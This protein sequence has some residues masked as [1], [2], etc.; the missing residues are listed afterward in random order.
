MDLDL[1]I[2][3]DAT[4]KSFN[5]LTIWSRARANFYQTKYSEALKDFNKLLEIKP[6][7]TL[8]LG[9]RGETY[10][11]LEKY[12][13][14]LIDFNNL[15]EKEP[16]NYLAL[17]LR[18][19]TYLLLENYNEAL[20][21]F[22]NLLEKDPNNYRALELR[23]KTYLMLKKYNEALIDFNKLLELEPNSALA[24]RLRGDTYL[25]S[26]KYNEALM[27][28]NKS[29]ELEPNNTFALELR[30]ETYLKLKNYH[31]ALTD[32]NNLLEKEPNNSRASE[33]RG[34]TYLLSEKY[35]EALTDFNNLL[36]N[37][38]NN[39]RAL[40]LR[41]ETYLKLKKYNEALMD[42][43]LLEIQLNNL[44]F[45]EEIID[46]YN[47]ILKIEPNNTLAL[48]FRGNNYKILKKYKEALHDFNNILKINPDDI[49]VLNLIIETEKNKN[50]SI[51]IKTQKQQTRIVNDIIT[52]S[53]EFINWIP[54]SQFKDIKYIAEGG[55]GVVNSAILI[56][57]KENEIKV[58]LKNLHNSKDMTDDFLKEVI[59]HGITSS[60]DFI[61]QCY[62]ITKDPNTN[63]NIMVMEFAEDGNLHK[64]LMLNFD[65][66][67]W[68]TKL[69]RLYCIATGL[70]QIH[71]NKLIHRD[72]HSGNILMG[73]NGILGS[74]RIADLG[75]CR[76]IDAL[77]NYVYGVIPYIAPEIFKDSSYSQAS[78]IY[79]FG[80]LMW[81]FTSGH[82]PFFNRPHNSKLMCKI[83]GG[84][85]PEITDDTPEL[86]S[87]LMFRCWNSN[88]LN[89]P[90]IKEI[91]EQIYK[92]CWGKEN[93]DQFIQAEQLR[94]ISVQ[95]KFLE[96][97]EGNNY[98]SY[99]SEAIYTSRPLN[100][101]I[102]LSNLMLIGHKEPIS[103][104]KDY[105][106]V[107]EN[108]EIEEWF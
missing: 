64:N 61:L 86:F 17:G 62:G 89:R 14:A 92:W 27:D 70:E 65:E 63:N 102:S 80:I 29:L 93:Q 26:E 31:E 32:F 42:F 55:F 88:P 83:I 25:F 40:E 22:N 106:S 101:T 82:R 51:N 67:T 48:K 94:K 58:A 81:E 97:W 39:S 103:K 8:T 4:E 57:D 105:K 72:L 90:N 69:E 2:S 107:Q 66:I 33:L 20:T 95:L 54:Y 16:N 84:L 21:D 38:P 108:F 104:V 36:E 75:L 12:N 18:G 87:D 13:E 5:A 41:G 34:E 91:K 53:S 73:V 9:F 23:G 43:N 59:S 15:L 78:D 100:S 11:K 52:E 60:S 99:H 35:N 10:Q 76:N 47:E 74:I 19:E 45:H 44:D 46:K 56:K 77:T 68:Q 85:R 71:N 30:G 24:L 37:E 1:P 96:E 6:N 79:S 50:Q 28:F 7:D 3:Q 49:S 98:S